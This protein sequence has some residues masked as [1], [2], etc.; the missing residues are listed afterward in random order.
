MLQKV[1]FSNIY[2]KMKKVKTS[3]LSIVISFYIKSD[4]FSKKKK[5]KRKYKKKKHFSNFLAKRNKFSI[6]SSLFLLNS[7]IS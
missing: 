1:I 3:L 2:N 4:I 5:I 7:N 6:K